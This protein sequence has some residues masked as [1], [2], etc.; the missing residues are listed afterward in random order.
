MS[1]GLPEAGLPNKVDRVY[2]ILFPPWDVLQRHSQSGSLVRESTVCVEDNVRLLTSELLDPRWN[3]LLK[4]P[5][6]IFGF[7]AVLGV[8]RK[9][10]FIEVDGVVTE[11]RQ[12]GGTEAPGSGRIGGGRN[13]PVLLNRNRSGLADAQPSE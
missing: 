13:I 5:V 12:V 6:N 3:A 10:P 7:S 9:L 2:A 4:D 11:S 8:L 1:D